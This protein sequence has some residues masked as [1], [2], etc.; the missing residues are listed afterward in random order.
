[1]S[2][3]AAPTPFA[4]SDE[5][6]RD[7]LTVSL[8]GIIFYTPVYDPAGSGELI[9]FAFDYLNPAAQRMMR[10][11]E[12]PTL[13]HTEQWPQS[14][15][16]G[17]FAFHIDAFLSG[18]PRAYEV[19]Y[20][21]DGY[22][23]YYRLAARRSGRGLVVSF[24]DTADQPRTAVEVALRESQAREQQ[25]LA[26]AEA[27][28]QRF[29][30]VLME[31]PA[32]VAVYHGSD[33]IYQLV[34]PAYQGL[35]PHRSFLGRPFR[36][37]TP[38]ANELGVVA[39][40]DRVYQTGEPFYAQ[41]M[42]GWFD[43][44]GTGQPVQLFINLYLHPLRNAQGHIDGI[45]DFS[46]DVTAQVLA[47]REAEQ[48]N[49]ELEVR[50]FER[51]QALR[52]AQAESVAAAQ[53]L[54][55]VTESL[56]S[57]T[58]TV[59]ATGQVL[60]VSPQWYAYTG[61]APEASIGEVWPQLIHPDD[62]PA[63]ARE[64]GAALT[65]GRAWRYE[66]R[67]LGADDQYRWFASQGVPE[68]LAEATAAGWSRQWFGSNLNIDDLKQAQHALEQQE[69]RQREIL[70]QSPALIATLTGPQH[71]FSFTNPGYDAL[72]GQRAELGRPVAECLPEVVAQG[73]ID[74]LD[75][76]YR[77]GQPYEVRETPIVLG[78]SDGAAT[79]FLD[80]TYQPLRDERG[81]TTGVLSFVLDV[82]ERVQTRR[83]ADTAQ[84]QLLVAAEQAAAQRKTFYEVF[85]Q[86]T[87]LVALVR[88]P[89]HRFEYVNPAYQAV[90][91]GRQL[92]GLDVAVAVPEMR[93]QGFVAVLD[94][95]YQTG[96]TRHVPEAPFVLAPAL[97]QPAR[98]AYYDVTYQAYREAGQI[99]GISIFAYDVTEQVLGRRER[100]AQ[101]QR[102]HDLFM[103]AP[104][105]ICILAGP[106][107]VFE[108]VNP[109][110]Q[111]LLPGRA[112]LGR[113][114]LDALPELTGT[115]VAHALF[116]VY[117]TGNTH[118]EAGILVPL[119]SPS[120][121][122]EDRYF[123]YI[124]QA[125]RDAHGQPDG[126]MVFSFEVT[127]QAQARQ[128]AQALAAE[129]SAANQQ[130]TRTN[131][132]LDTF[133]YTASHD[134]K[135]PITNIEGLLG[136]LRDELPTQGPAP[137]GEVPYLLDLMQDSVER[138]RHTI[139]HLTDLSKLQKEYEGQQPAQPVPLA[140]VIEGVRLDL[141]PLLQQTRG[142][143]DVDVRA[144]PTLTLA[145]KN[146]RSVVFNLL[147]NALKYRHPDRAPLVQMRARLAGDF[148]VLEVQ[149]NGLGFD[150]GREAQLFAMFQRLHTHVEGSGVGLYMVKRLVENAGGHI[151]V[152]STVGEGTT[153]T[154]TL[155]H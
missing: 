68:P 102:L 128:Q 35:F 93:E 140:P 1:M 141:A 135:A 113:P 58:F 115:S 108:L 24:T 75:G 155:P 81:F 70:T 103:Q 34:N 126:V 117:E 73:F 143:L 90:F 7:L 53:H 4:P 2:P 59:D 47:R 32:Y 6:L 85:E 96:K 129:L 16:H 3:P 139:D 45:L 52:H 41:E 101:R 13:T 80:I 84:A 121:A 28:R 5:L 95:V 89:G 118:E 91:A 20:Q 114:L 127:E 71:R 142:R 97:G 22:D 106:A 122:L 112:L 123:N 147:S 72:V 119:A 43:I 153:F 134:L 111:A 12:R 130:L 148:A 15:A 100:E 60:Y 92:V 31:L 125:R 14:K 151:T 61:M 11:P 25:A 82:T 63:V 27:Q 29:H 39:V 79:Q 149:D 131:V 36:E 30:E 76:V 86:T 144:V 65:E 38:E 50:V 74:L 37:G 83:Q 110:Y 26:E 107:L 66:F 8:T 19:N 69:L 67:L 40:F 94:E 78:P 137:A 33:H 49:Q 104:A 98:T 146:L 124:H 46:Y 120:G 136:A 138:F 99:A 10:M 54:L 9:D 145:E 87:A 150:V 109:G 62:L 152:A 44:H 132:D 133:I 154:V 77:T 55:R 88:A 105:A 18:E 64:Y 21:A 48:L 51:T 57:T 56:P 42:E 116:Q 23:N 17:T